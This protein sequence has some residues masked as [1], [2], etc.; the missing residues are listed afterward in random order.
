MRSGRSTSKAS[1][2]CS[3]AATA[4]PYHPGRF[5]R[6]LLECRGLYST[7]IEL[8]KPVFIKVF[9]SSAFPPSSAPTTARPSLPS[10]SLGSHASALGGS[11]SAS[12][13]RPSSC[14]VSR[15]RMAVTN[16][17]TDP[18]ARSY[19]AAEGQPQC[20]AAPLR[21]IPPY[22]S[23]T[24]GRTRLSTMRLPTQS[25]NLPLEPTPTS[26]HLSRTL[27]TSRSERSLQTEGSAGTRVGS[28][29]VRLWATSSSPSNPSVP[30]C[31]RSTSDP[32]PSGGLTKNSSSFSTPTATQ[33]ET[34]SV[35]HQPTPLCQPSGAL[36]TLGPPTGQDSRRYLCRPCSVQSA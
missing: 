19:S 28:T 27:S 30:L 21:R 35:N 26:S 24:S 25:I 12:V 10:A 2:R 11:G 20:P 9:V 3:T 7:S 6:F 4:F 17:C 29:S 36:F 8:A 1:S 13:L 23:I 33:E 34:Q 22:L 14:L 15:S 18:Q 5:S 32:L 31:G 16:S